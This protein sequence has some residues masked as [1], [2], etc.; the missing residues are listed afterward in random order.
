MDTQQIVAL[1]MKLFS[2]AGRGGAEGGGVAG[3]VLQALKG[4]LGARLAPENAQRLERVEQNAATPED[5]QQLHSGLT[6]LL[7]GDGDLKDKVG[8]LLG[9][10]MESSSLL[11]SPGLDA[12]APG[13]GADGAGGGLPGKL[14]DLLGGLFK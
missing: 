3:T 13:G 6:D 2:G 11:K 7:D 10:V 4:L 14:G 8:G 9:P 5:Q 1:V 12:G